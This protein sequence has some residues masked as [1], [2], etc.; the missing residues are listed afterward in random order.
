MTSSTCPFLGLEDD[1]TTILYFP[2]SGN[3][4]HLVNPIAPVNLIHQQSYCLSKEHVSCPVFA[5]GRGGPIP[6]GI[7]VPEYQPA[8]PRRNLF[9]GGFVL[10]FLII[11]LGVGAL[12]INFRDKSSSPILPTE[13]IEQILDANLTPNNSTQDIVISNPTQFP[14]PLNSDNVSTES[15]ISVTECQQPNGWIL[16]LVKPTDS[17][18]R[19]SEIFRISLLEL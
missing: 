3:Y 12:W 1:P 7:L 17:L 16:Y 19:L 5:S 8:I 11:G 18:F 13:D 2:S 14:T 4:C 15:G 10:L 6:D 9:V